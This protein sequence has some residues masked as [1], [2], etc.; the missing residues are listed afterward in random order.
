MDGFGD[1]SMVLW[2]ERKHKNVL[3][4]RNA[5]QHV[6]TIQS[7]VMQVT[8]RLQPIQDKACQLLADIEGRGTELEQVVTTTEQCLE[9]PVSEAVI[10]E[11]TEQEVVAQQQVEAAQAKLEAFE[12]EL[13]R[14]E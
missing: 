7:R 4:K 1:K 2:S 8:Q 11:F 10:Q 12:A 3:N 9:G 14:P 6:H 5:Q 13:P